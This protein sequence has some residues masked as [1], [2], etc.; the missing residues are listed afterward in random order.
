MIDLFIGSIFLSNVLLTKYLGIRIDK[1]KSLTVTILI[2]IIT[3]ISSIVNYF[4][5]SLLLKLNAIY[6]RNLIFIL[7]IV[8]VSSIV[9][10]IYKLITNNEDDILPVVVSNSLILGVSLFVT[11]SGYDLINTIVYTIGSSVGYILVMFLFYY[12]DKELSKRKVLVS[13]KG[14]PIMLIT[15]GI[16]CMV[17]ERL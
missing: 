16:L 1:D 2:S 8:I 17:L 13:F 10:M 14:Y 4:V 5:Y 11:S 7:D 12:M 3:I 9:L 6:L 15:L